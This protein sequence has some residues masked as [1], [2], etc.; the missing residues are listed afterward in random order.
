M[1]AKFYDGFNAVVVLSELN[2]F[3]FS[4]YS[5]K[6]ELQN[7]FITFVEVRFILCFIPDALKL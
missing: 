5:I 4:F 3:S 6:V 2:L 7:G 1:D